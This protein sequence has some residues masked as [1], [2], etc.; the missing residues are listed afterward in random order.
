MQHAQYVLIQMQ[1]ADMQWKNYCNDRCTR[2]LAFL[3]VVVVVV[4]VVEMVKYMRKR[5]TARSRGGG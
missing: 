4:V 5:E 2:L 3:V 1:A